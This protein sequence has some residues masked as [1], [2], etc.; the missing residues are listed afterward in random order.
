MKFLWPL[1]VA[2][3]VDGATVTGTQSALLDQARKQSMENP[4]VPLNQ[5]APPG[6]YWP[7]EIATV[8]REAT[9]VLVA[10]L[11]KLKSYVA[12]GGDHILTD[13][14]IRAP[15]VI[16]GAFAM[17]AKGRPGQGT[18]LILTVYGGDVVLVGVQVRGTDYNRE[19]IND[20]AEFLLFLRE[21]P[22]KEP[23]RYQ[24]HYGAIFEVSGQ[25]A[26][27]L[28]KGA[29]EVFKGTIDP[30]LKEMIARVQ[31]AVMDRR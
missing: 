18:P 3:L 14:E 5:P 17:V 25:S 15:R 31:A 22:G 24:I 2:P 7:T 27:P 28:L 13:Y 8:S 26:R 21:T 4:G 11:S 10:R 1:I 20:G 23:G 6:D 16:A 19:A 29:D 12:P 30:Q 9:V